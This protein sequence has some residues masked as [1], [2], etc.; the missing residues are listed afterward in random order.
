MKPNDKKFECHQSARLSRKEF[1]IAGGLFSGFLL[2]RPFNSISLNAVSHND[3]QPWPLKIEGDELIVPAGNYPSEVQ[4]FEVEKEGRFRIKPV[5]VNTVTNE[6]LFLSS[7]KPSGFWKGTSLKGP[8]YDQLGVYQ[9]LIE[10]SLI[11]KDVEGN[12]LRKGDDYLVS[13]P[14]ALLGLGTNTTLTTE[15][16][17]FASYSYYLQRID[18]IGLDRNGITFLQEGT[19]S[20]VSPELPKLPADTVRFCNIYRPIQGISFMEEH[21]FPLLSDSKHVVTDTTRGR[22]N[23]T[24]GKLESG[25]SVNIV[26]WGDSITV[27]A[28]VKPGEGWADLLHTKLKEKFPNAK[29]NYTNHS[30]GGTRSMQWLHD[31]DFPDMP[32]LPADKCSFDLVANDKPDLV[33]MEFTNDTV[34]PNQKVLEPAYEMIKNKINDLGAELIICTPGRFLMEDYDAIIFKM[35][36]S[37]DRPYVSFVKKFAEKNNFAVADTSSRWDHLYKEGIPYPTILINAYN[38][39]NAFGHTLFVEEL[40]KCFNKE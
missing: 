23:K 10:D 24:L 33:V 34:L 32:K 28:D 29:I 36:K 11:I 16:K 35:K 20:L 21:L 5:T 7:E 3:V 40:L 39:P 27:G 25:E 13:A 26:A 19:P 15:S 18:S 2:C 14:F 31:G 38:H 4:M 17:V 12:V 37:D 9:S 1:L 8:Y 30:I 6:E 22:I